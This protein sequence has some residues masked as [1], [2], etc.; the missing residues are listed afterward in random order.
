MTL[1]QYINI[2]EKQPDQSKVV[3]IG[4]GNPHSWRGAYDELAFEPVENITIGEMLSEAREAVGSIYTGYKGGEYKMNEHTTINVEHE[5][6]YTDNEMLFQLLF[7][8]MFNLHSE[9]R[10]SYEK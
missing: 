7:D 4:L 1:Q 9:S 3:K 8:L 2:L 5:G 10:C 6:S